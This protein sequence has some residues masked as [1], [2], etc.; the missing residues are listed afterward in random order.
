[1]FVAPKPMPSNFIQDH[2]DAVLAKVYDGK[3]HFIAQYLRD[4]GYNPSD[5][6]LWDK[7][8]ADGWTMGIRRI[9]VS[10]MSE[11]AQVALRRFRSLRTTEAAVALAEILLK[12][13]IHAQ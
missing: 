2:I 3:E 13:V 4:T 1:M 11:D 9:G 8:T 5:C 12:E 10:V 6:E 7:T